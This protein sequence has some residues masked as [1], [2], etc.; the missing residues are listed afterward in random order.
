MLEMTARRFNASRFTTFST[1]SDKSRPG[2]GAGDIIKIAVNVRQ[3]GLSVN[4]SKAL[5][6]EWLQQNNNFGGTMYS[7]NN[8]DK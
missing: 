1:I 4:A 5:D 3:R 8:L 2:L 7:F 6:S